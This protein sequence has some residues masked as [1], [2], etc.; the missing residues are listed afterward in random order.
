MD[1]IQI[2]RFVDNPLLTPNPNSIWRSKGV[3]NAGVIYSDGI[4][5]MLFRASSRDDMSFSDLG[6][7]LSYN[8]S[9]W[10]ILDKPVLECGSNDW[11]ERGIEDPR[12]VEFNTWYYI[13]ATACFGG[14]GRIGIWRTKNFLQFEWVGIPFDIEDKDACI[15]PDYIDGWIYLIHRIAP[16]MWISKTRDFSLKTGWEDHQV[17]LKAKT[18]KIGIAGPPIKL[19]D[20]WL[21]IYHRR[22][23]EGIYELSFLILDGKNP[24]KILYDY[25]KPILTP[26]REHEKKGNVNNVV[27]S[28]A[29][30]DMGSY[31]LIYWGGGDRVVCGGTLNKKELEKYATK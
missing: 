18:G 12:I 26:E 9:Q 7:A 25:E 10:Y 4:F 21:V 3:F 13:F 17:L 16:D 2:H 31:I 5:K 30:I 24:T 6:L 28:C 15:I 8:G 27:F 14:G 23:I 1:R 20:N 11:C 29:T 19:G 22:T